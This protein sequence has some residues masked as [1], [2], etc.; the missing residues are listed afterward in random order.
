MGFVSA[1]FIASETLQP[2]EICGTCGFL[3]IFAS[4]EAILSLMRA[5]D[6]DN[7]VLQ[8]DLLNDFNIKVMTEYYMV[9]RTSPDMVQ[10]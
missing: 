3:L 5:L 4:E 8:Q 7:P 1:G 9:D 6:D 10:S 2:R